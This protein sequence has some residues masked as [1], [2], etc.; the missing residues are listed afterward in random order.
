V[1]NRSRAARPGAS[2]VRT[3]TWHAALALE[4]EVEAVTEEFDS[5]AAA[6]EGADELARRFAGGEV[7]YRAAY[8]VPREAYFEQLDEVVGR[9]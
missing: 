9:E 5:R 7:D 6:L 2:R 8:Q 4:P 1:S 3:G